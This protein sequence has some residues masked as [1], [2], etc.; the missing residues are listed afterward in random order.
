MWLFPRNAAGGLGRD[1]V[2]PRHLNSPSPTYQ[3]HR[4]VQ[5]LQQCRAISSLEKQQ[6]WK[7]S[8]EVSLE[9]NGDQTWWCWRQGS[10]QAMINYWMTVWTGEISVVM[11]HPPEHA[12]PCYSCSDSNNCNKNELQLCPLFCQSWDI[13]V[14]DSISL[15]TGKQWPAAP[16]FIWQ[17]LQGLPTPASQ[18][19]LYLWLP[20]SKSRKALY[21]EQQLVRPTNKSL[22]TMS[23]FPEK[24]SFH[25][26][27]ELA[28]TDDDTHFSS[29]VLFHLF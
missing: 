18:L 15:W 1:L 11:Q 20:A 27:R 9:V 3:P 14:L 25:Y 19:F 6:I 4:G 16:H 24:D 22:Q 8:L 26:L 28:F 23:S 29:S 12:N 5:T 13:N 2:S 7:G 10:R 21:Q 17:I